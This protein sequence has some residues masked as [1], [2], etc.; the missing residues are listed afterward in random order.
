MSP[1]PVVVPDTVVTPPSAGEKQLGTMKMY[2]SS[3][4]YSPMDVVGSD[5]T[6]MSSRGGSPVPP[7]TF[8]LTLIDKILSRIE[9]KDKFFSLEFFPP[10]TKS[11]AINLLSRYVSLD[12]LNCVAKINIL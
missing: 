9:S 6:P 7:S 12:I 1:H 3:P 2:E 11:G 5:M 10:R 8:E 4:A